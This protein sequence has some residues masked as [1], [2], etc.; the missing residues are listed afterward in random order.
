MP[1]RAVETRLRGPTEPDSREL[2][3]VNSPPG[4]GPYQPIHALPFAACAAAVSGARSTAPAPAGNRSAEEH[5]GLPGP[6]RAPVPRRRRPSA[7]PRW[8][9]A[10]ARRLLPRSMQR[11]SRDVAQCRL[12]RRTPRT[13]SSALHAVG[14][15]DGRPGV[16]AGKDQ[17]HFNS[18]GPFTS[19]PFAI[20]HFQ[21]P[22]DH[23]PALRQLT[24]VIIH[25]EDPFDAGDEPRNILDLMTNKIYTT[26]LY[27]ST[28]EGM[29]NPIDL[30]LL[31]EPPRRIELRDPIGEAK[32]LPSI[33]VR[34]HDV[35]NFTEVTK[36]T[37]KMPSDIVKARHYFNGLP[38]PELSLNPCLQCIFEHSGALRT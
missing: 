9:P 8:R 31:I 19:E 12:S 10:R 21:S 18:P 6:R 4:R 11:R 33:D 36:F 22:T 30:P 28:K 26:G 35:L 2:A 23:L 25:E 7:L 27:R 14:P 24:L 37:A 20:R 29:R 1:H 15:T 17:N 5:P 34:V 32:L 3:K 16:S 38:A 13:Y